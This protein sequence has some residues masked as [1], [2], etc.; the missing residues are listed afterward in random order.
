MLKN[1]EDLLNDASN[2]CLLR[3]NS[4]IFGKC[5][6]ENKRERREREK[7]KER[8]EKEKKRSSKNEGRQI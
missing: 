1:D 5:K 4:C 8:R 2:T 3:W 7:E 6:K